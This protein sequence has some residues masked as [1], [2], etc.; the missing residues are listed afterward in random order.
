M[1]FWVLVAF[2]SESNCQSYVVGDKYELGHPQQGEALE[3][4]QDEPSAVLDPRRRPMPSVHEFHEYLSKA[5]AAC[6]Y[7]YINLLM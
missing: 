1:E 2:G 3:I 4:L 7:S 6:L 5:M